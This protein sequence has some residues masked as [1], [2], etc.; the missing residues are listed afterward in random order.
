M[1]LNIYTL[2]LTTLIIIGLLGRYIGKEGVKSLINVTLSILSLISVLALYEYF[3]DNN[4]LI[5]PLLNLKVDILDLNIYLYLEDI[6]VLMLLVIISITYVVLIYSYDY[7]INDPHIIRF[8]LYILLF[9]F[10]MIILISSNSLPIIFIGWEGVG[11]SS[12]LL[13]SFWYSRFNTQIGS[14]IA[15][16]M[17]R[18]GDVFYLLGVLAS[19]LLIGSVDLISLNINFNYNYDLLLLPL[20]LACM[21][22]SAQLYLHLWLPYSMEG[23]TP[24]SALIHAATMVTAGVFL[25]LKLNQILL[26]SYYLLIILFIIGTLTAFVGSSLAILSLDIKELIAYSTMSQLGYMMSIIGLKGGNLS[27]YHLVFHAYFKALLFL[28]AGGIIHSILDIQ[29]LRK[30]GGLSKLLPV[31]SILSILGILSLIAF[32]FSTGFYSKEGLLNYSYSLSDLSS[33]YS[34]I[35]LLTSAILTIIYNYY[36]YIKIFLKESRLPLF[37]LKYNLH[38]FSLHLLTPLFSLSIFTIFIGYLLSKWSYINNL[39][40]N[41]NLF[42]IIPLYIKLIPLFFIVA[43]FIIIRLSSIKS[44]I[45]LS[46]LSTLYSFKSLYQLISSLFF[47]LSYRVFFKLFDYGYLDLLGPISGDQ[48]IKLK[49]NNLFDK[50][51]PLSILLTLLLLYL[52]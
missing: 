19:L 2:P 23:P 45:K 4:Q 16:L 21:S 47:T 3:L 43:I 35:I 27:F 51:N 49:V 25:L 10:F 30:M 20:F 1:Y 38:P 42:D 28:T 44:N 8:N 11:L 13:I 22:K 6:S 14:L 41:P 29:D 40:Q 5:A 17:N 34:Y 50:L 15:L 37:L 9:I 48:L 18:V 26:S 52:L 32:P 36:F 31:Q 7:M 46:I 24:I 12:F 39:Y 33:H